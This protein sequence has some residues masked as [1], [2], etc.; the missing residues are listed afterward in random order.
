MHIESNPT[1]VAV[2]TIYSDAP[3]D[4]HVHALVDKYS[5]LLN[6]QTPQGPSKKFPGYTAES[7]LLVNKFETKWPVSSDVLLLQL[8]DDEGGISGA[9]TWHKAKVHGVDVQH[10]SNEGVQ[11]RLLHIHDPIRVFQAAIVPTLQGTTCTLF[12][13]SS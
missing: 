7:L 1:L 5:T 9:S 6:Y 11:R 3:F 13:G 10:L 4:I 2:L 12:K 8:T